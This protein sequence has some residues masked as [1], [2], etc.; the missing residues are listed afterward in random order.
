MC[1][2]EVHELSGTDTNVTDSLGYIN[3]VNGPYYAKGDG[4]TD[5]TAA[6]QKALNDAGTLVCSH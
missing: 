4:K 1:Y 3:A 5:N 2:W 6:V